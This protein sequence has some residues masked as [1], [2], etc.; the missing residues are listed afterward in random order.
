MLKVGFIGVGGIAGSYLN[1]LAKLE[2]VRVTAVCDV[3]RERAEAIA[4]PHNAS[5][6][7]DFH[8]MLEDE[9]L[10][11]LFICIPPSAHTDQE[12]EAARRGIPMFV[13]KPVGL[14]LDT[15]TK[16]L[17]VIRRN[18]VLT[19]VGYMW[20]H[21]DLTDKAQELLSNR[22]IGMVIGNV[23]V[24]TPETAWWRIYSE[25][26]GQIV[27]Q[28]THLYDL[29]RYFCG[30]VEEVQAWGG[31]RLNRAI[32]FEDVTTANLRFANGV[33]GN[34]TSTSLVRTG[35]YTLELIGNDVHLILEYA[36]NRMTG[37]VGDERIEFHAR[38]SGYYIQVERFVRALREGKP[39]LIR[40]DFADGVR[41]LALTLAVN[42]SLQTGE[43]IR[44]PV[45]P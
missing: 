2:D 13:A 31:S 24:N 38:E 3:N 4:K 11:A 18:G 34:I 22:E 43:P 8:A 37:N 45:V 16:A 30:E 44:V 25:S 7:L 29:A 10:D 14:C 9:S 19:S 20:R 36:A 32:D 41:S 33:V 39:E 35:R 15:A 27:E 28:S 40:S 23:H 26:G 21:S 17:E 12:A 6:Y 1:S 5:V 42:E